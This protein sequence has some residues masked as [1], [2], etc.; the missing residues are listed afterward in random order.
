[1]AFVIFT[2]CSKRHVVL[3]E[4]GVVFSVI[5]EMK[6]LRSV[7]GKWQLDYVFC[8]ALVTRDPKKPFQTPPLMVG[9]QNSKLGRGW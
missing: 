6:T 7:H 4:A 5:L 3:I 8:D 9:A 2:Y 1:M